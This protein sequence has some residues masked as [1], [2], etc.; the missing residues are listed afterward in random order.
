MADLDA[1]SLQ[2]VRDFFKTYYAPNNAAIAVVGDFNEAA[3]KKKIEK[4]FGDIPKQKSPPP[5]D[6]TEQPLGGEKRREIT[7]PLARL[8]RYEAA[9]KTVTGD[10]PDVP[11]L[12]V[13]G[14]ILSRGRTGRLYS[15]IV[16][17]RLATN[18]SAGGFPSRG[19]GAFS[20]SATLPPGG[21]VAALEKA[22][23]AEIA[24]VQ[25]DGVTDEEI[26]KAR[27]QARAGAVIGGGRGR[28]GGGGGGIL[29]ALGRANQL[30]QN[31]VYW[32]DPGRM[33]T[34]LARLE[35]VTAADVKR[36][37]VKYLTKDNRVVVICRPEEEPDD[38]G[39]F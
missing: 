38:M 2:D 22:I 15:A 26:T 18:I 17:K 28:G 14:S 33:N 27:I 35:A 12:T 1:A 23:E 32:N 8:T 36:V 25:A 5:V 24:R 30:S 19:P 31:A 34:N 29:T 13:L 11:A 20:F 10:D 21:D 39:G 9:Y 7:D 16:E 37:A 3:T 6:M 4:Y